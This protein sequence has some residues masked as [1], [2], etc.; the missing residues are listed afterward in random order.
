[1]SRVPRGSQVQDESVQCFRQ[2]HPNNIDRGRPNPMTFRP[3]PNE[4]GLMSVTLS[5]KRDAPTTYDLYTRPKEQGGSG[6]RSDGVWAVTVEEVHGVNLTAHE[7][8]PDDAH[9]C[10]NFK[11]CPDDATVKTK[12]QMLLMKAIARGRVHPPA[13]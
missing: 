9:G 4:A 8:P 5:S 2:V 7:D 6:L 1:M 10:I 11:G 3:R 12:A 13:V